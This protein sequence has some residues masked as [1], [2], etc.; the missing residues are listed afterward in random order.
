M[1]NIKKYNEISN[2]LKNSSN[3]AKIVA[4][5]KNHLKGKYLG[6][7]FSAHWCGPCRGFT[8]KL[9]EWYKKDLSKKNFEIIFVSSDRD[10]GAFDGY[11]NE[12]PWVALPEWS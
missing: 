6:I 4:I 9:S 8:P 1:F 5:S 12:M 3:L 10:Q 2:F 7:Y 11:L